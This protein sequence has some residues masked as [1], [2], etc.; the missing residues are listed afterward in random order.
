VPPTTGDEDFGSSK[1]PVR[2]RESAGW[3]TPSFSSLCLQPSHYLILAAR[4][5]TATVTKDTVAETML[6]SRLDNN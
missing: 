2:E 6:R 1:K 3:A 4:F 5:V